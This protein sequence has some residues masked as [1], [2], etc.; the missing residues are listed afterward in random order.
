MKANA[1]AKQGD[2][3]ASVRDE[4]VRWLVRLRSGECA[5]AE[6]EDFELWL[7]ADEGHR[8]AYEDVEGHWRW[9]EAFRTR[10]FRARE[11]A[12]RYRPPRRSIRLLAGM[13][14]VA[15]LGA[16]LQFTA[17]GSDGWYGMRTT[18]VTGRGEHEVVS[19]ADGSTLELN[20][21]TVVKTHINRWRRSVELVRGE[22]YFS[23]VHEESRPFEVKAGGGVIHDL[24]TAFDV[25]VQPERVLVA[26]DDGSVRVEARDSRVLVAGQQLAYTRSGEFMHVAETPI[27]DL[28]AW[29]RG[30]V[31]FRDRPLHEVLDELGRY[32]DIHVRLAES[33]P[34]TRHLS[35]SFR[36]DDLDGALRQIAATLSL[37]LRHAG[38]A[39]VLLEPF[40]QPHRRHGTP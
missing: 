18:R 27:H 39:D 14:A 17:S 26:V 35:G 12:L 24:G 13:G 15:L 36:T 6:R 32:R 22:A 34:G 20:T 11:E 1:P 31:V 30:M 9:M 19:L 4:A 16:S 21:D 5:E 2:Y 7:R 38:A 23:V 10:R 29:R 33:A 40:P 37:R 8:K 28:T 3:P 25:R